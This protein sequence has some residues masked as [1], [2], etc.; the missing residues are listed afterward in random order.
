MKKRGRGIGCNLYGVGY[1]FNRP[2]HASAYIEVADDGTVTLLSGVCDLGQGS[3]TVL[4]QIAAEELGINYE[5]VRIISADTAITPDSLASSASRQTYVSG[6]AVKKAAE[7]IKQRFAK[8]AAEILKCEIEDIEF[9]EGVVSCKADSSKY[10]K[11]SEL[12]N[13]MH[14]E[15]KQTIGFAYF[16]N[17]TADVNHETNQGDAYAHYI[18]GSQ[19]ADVEVD[20][21][22]GEVTVL[23]I[24]AA[25]DC[26]K[27]I[28][29]QN[30][31]QQIDGGV[32]QGMGYA[33]MEEIIMKDG[34]TLTPS[35]AKYLIPTSQD[36]PEIVTYIVESADPRGPYGAKGLG[37][38]PIIPTAAAI[39][40]AVYDA[41][42][43]RITSLPVTPEKILAELEKKKQSEGF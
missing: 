23:R 18:Y 36:S 40:N 20:T 22:T 26:G 9:S 33:I 38:G 16:D 30:V 42:G 28:N 27:A 13:Q 21:Q 39:V 3:D 7:D 5:D 19:V 25:Q 24:G 35:F 34:K 4:C 2:D 11:F 12:A 17:T 14:L 15:G 41:I 10:I 29:P 6:N 31:E 37:E 32:V 8:F 43:I 1:G